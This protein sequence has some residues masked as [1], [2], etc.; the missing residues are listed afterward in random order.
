MSS[1][2]QLGVSGCLLDMHRLDMVRY[3]GV[4]VKKI[5]QNETNLQK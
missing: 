5:K 1:S 4:E 2:A 3:V